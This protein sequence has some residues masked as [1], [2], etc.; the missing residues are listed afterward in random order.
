[1]IDRPESL[2]KGKDIKYLAWKVYEVEVDTNDHTTLP[3][4]DTTVALKQA[5]M[6]KQ[7]D[8][9][10]VTCSKAVGSPY[11]VVTVTEAGLDDEKCLL[12]IVGVRA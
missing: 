2:L 10:T 9:A 8:G 4:F 12:F 11:N 3:D 6:A 5:W 7:S 1:L